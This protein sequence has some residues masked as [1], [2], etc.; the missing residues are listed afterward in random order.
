MASNSTPSQESVIFEIDFTNPV[1]SQRNGKSVSDTDKA[2]TN[3]EIFTDNTGVD[4]SLIH[5]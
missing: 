5:I 1:I 3:L 2:Y 4:L